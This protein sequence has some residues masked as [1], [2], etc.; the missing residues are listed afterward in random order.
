ADGGSGELGDVGT[1]SLGYELADRIL[2][3]LPPLSFRYPAPGSAGALV[4]AERRRQVE[5][6]GRT[7]ESDLQYKRNELISA[8]ICYAKAGALDGMTRQMYPN[9]I[10]MKPVTWPWDE[11]SWKPKDPERDLVRAAAL[12]LAEIDRQRLHGT[13]GMSV[14]NPACLT[15]VAIDMAQPGADQT[16]IVEVL[17]PVHN[18][19]HNG[20]TCACHQPGSQIMHCVPCC[21]STPAI[22]AD[23]VAVERPDVAG[24]LAKAQA[25]EP[26][27]RQAYYTDNKAALFVLRE[28]KLVQVAITETLVMLDNDQLWWHSPGSAREF[29]PVFTKDIK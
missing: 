25:L 19:P 23:A 11:R 12:I 14:V 10:A 15:N 21:P 28:E 16:V 7:P 29:H 4:L 3:A 1:D 18:L 6:E 5:E 22:P 20:C 17:N 2:K 13:T 9:D 26:T 8:A 24:I 27:L